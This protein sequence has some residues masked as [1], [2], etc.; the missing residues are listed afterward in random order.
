M[1][2]VSSEDAQTYTVV[3]NDEGQHS[4]WQADLPVPPGWREVGMRG[5]RDACF[6]H[7]EQRWTDMRPASV[8]RAAAEAV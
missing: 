3:V 8:R 4:I 1:G 2:R 6:D 7:L 5:T